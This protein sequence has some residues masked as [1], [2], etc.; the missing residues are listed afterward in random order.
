MFR[1]S[2]SSKPSHHPLHHLSSGSQRISSP[3]EMPRSLE[4]AHRGELRPEPPSASW[5]PSQAVTH[6]RAGQSGLDHQPSP[7]TPL[8]RQGAATAAPAVTW[9]YQRGSWSG[10]C[11]PVPV[12]AHVPGL[13]PPHTE[14]PPKA[15][16]IGIGQWKLVPSEMPSREAQGRSSLYPPGAQLAPGGP[17]RI[18]PCPGSNSLKTIPGQDAARLL[19]LSRLGER[20]QGSR[21]LLP[22]APP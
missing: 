12:L 16:V 7:P 1:T 8:R 11:S 6:A 2:C 9:I 19:S 10:P 5:A 22:R 17:S 15:Q 4:D 21:L 3:P 20:L 14:T 13:T 18:T